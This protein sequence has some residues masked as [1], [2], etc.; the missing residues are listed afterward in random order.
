M[1]WNVLNSK[2]FL[3]LPKNFAG[4]TPKDAIFLISGHSIENIFGGFGTKSEKIRNC[5]LG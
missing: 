4:T 5:P 3:S 1:S 2:T